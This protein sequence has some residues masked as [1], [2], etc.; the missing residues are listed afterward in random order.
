MALEYKVGQRVQIAVDINDDT[1]Y[2]PKGSEGTVTTVLD[3][4]TYEV[5]VDG[6]QGLYQFAGWEL[7]RVED[8]PQPAHGTAQ[9]I[10]SANTA[11]PEPVLE[12]NGQIVH[13]G[14]V[15]DVVT[16]IAEQYAL[17][18]VLSALEEL[19][20]QLIEDV[21]RLTRERDAAVEALMPFAQLKHYTE[22]LHP[23]HM[24]QGG[25]LCVI[26]SPAAIVRPYNIVSG[27]GEG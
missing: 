20:A 24:S 2:P 23:V 4:E 16:R 26:L 22:P 12:I 5:R 14:Q 25:E 9:A 11:M 1:P 17:G 21:A 27:Q 7:K 13:A 15:V 6:W 19:N 18:N 10:V 3:N 8:D